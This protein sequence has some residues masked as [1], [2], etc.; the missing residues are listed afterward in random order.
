MRRG[1]LDWSFAL[2]V[3][4]LVVLG[5][6]M[7]I[8]T[9][10]VVGQS[11]FNDSFFFIKKHIIFMVLGAIAFWIG[12]MLPPVFYK[13]I[14]PIGFSVAV[15][16]ILL[17]LIPGVGVKIAGARRW[18]NVGIT[19]IQPVELMKFFI[20]VFLSMALS[21]KR[22][23]L[24]KF[25][26]GC[27]PILGMVSLPVGILMLQ[28][29]LGNSGLILMVSFTLLF[30]SAVPLRHLFSLVGLGISVIVLNILAHPYQMERIKGF[31]SPWDD[32]L[33]RNY[34]MV[35]SLIAI[36]SGGFMGLG[37]GESKLKF[38]YLPLQ[39]SD[40]IFSIV[41]EEG[42]F[43]MATIVVLLFGIVGVRGFQ[44]GMKSR[45]L[46]TYYLAIGLTLLLVFQAVIN[47]CVVTG[48]FPVTG[49]PLTFMSFGGTAL[50]TSLFYAGVICS[51]SR[52]ENRNDS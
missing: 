25:V 13:K 32:P 23:S 43:V 24:Q 31:M 11:N 10:S 9:S 15:L 34:H 7:I 5:L 26:T 51:I 16:L 3:F 52:E 39:Y 47:M 44:I 48:L 12:Y 45:S 33:G 50:V 20:V 42:G 49:I 35:Q 41:C 22:E 30:L 37:L 19:Y 14:F 21:N 6:I 46:Y 1:T 27:V 17:T 40:F 28:P 38:F 18:L 4:I 29:D 2:P 8:S 36:G